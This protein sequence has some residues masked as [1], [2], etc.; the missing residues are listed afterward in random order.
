M[1]KLDTS[2]QKYQTNENVR[3]ENY[4]GELSYPMTD[5]VSFGTYFQ[6]INFMSTIL[7]N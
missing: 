6:S 1:N 5:R 2:D 4:K 7:L 3:D